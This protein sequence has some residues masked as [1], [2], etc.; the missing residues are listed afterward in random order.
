MKV[1]Q[2][3]FSS[4]TSPWKTPTGHPSKQPPKQRRRAGHGRKQ[5]PHAHAH[6]LAD[7][8]EEA[9]WTENGMSRT[10]MQG[11]WME[12]KLPARPGAH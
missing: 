1:I 6:Q 12:T 4:S 7:H 3:F 5:Q 2:L 8:T 9:E 10:F 11:T